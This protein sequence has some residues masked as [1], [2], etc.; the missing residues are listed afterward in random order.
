MGLAVTKIF[1]LRQDFGQ[2][3]PQGLD[4]CHESMHQPIEKMNSDC[5]GWEIQ[6]VNER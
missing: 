2:I 1:P 3:F 6:N 5:R 4:K